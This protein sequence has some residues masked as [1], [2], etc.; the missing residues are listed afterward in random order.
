MAQR[1]ESREEYRELLSAELLDF[2]NKNA[3]SVSTQ[4]KCSHV[5]IQRIDREKHRIV[6]VVNDSIEVSYYLP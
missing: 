5:K 4:I 3:K 1:E 2:S 6:V